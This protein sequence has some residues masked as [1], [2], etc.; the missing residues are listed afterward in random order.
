[1]DYL[2]SSLSI[3]QYKDIKTFVKGTIAEDAPI[4]PVSAQLKYNIDVLCEYITKIPSPI[5]DFTLEPQLTIIRSFDVNKPGTSLEQIKG[6][7]V[8]GAVIKGVL[9]VGQKIEIRPGLIIKDTNGL[10]FLSITIVLT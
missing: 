6:G 1:M 2:V 9:K 4:I 5:R 10:F 7:V 8:G 3:K